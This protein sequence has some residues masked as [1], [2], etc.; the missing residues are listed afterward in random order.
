MTSIVLF[1]YSFIHSRYFYSASSSPLLLTGI[2]GYS[3][4]SV[5]TPKRYR[6][7]WVKDL[8][9]FSCFVCV[10]TLPLNLSIITSFRV[11]VNFRRF[12][13]RIPVPMPDIKI[14]CTL[15]ESLLSK[16][17]SPLRPAE[18]TEIAR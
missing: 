5:N 13:K 6:Q 11:F 3:T 17:G 10:D 16:Q 1:C 12:P 4:V 15:L 18:I 9:K 7:L 2:P 8:P 14:R